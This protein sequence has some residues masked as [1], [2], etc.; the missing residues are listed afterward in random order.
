M[1]AFFKTDKFRQVL[2]DDEIDRVVLGEDCIEWL[3]VQLSNGKS[4]VAKRPIYEDWGWTMALTV[5]G[6]QL[7]LNVQDWSFEEGQTWHLWLE[8][9]GVLIRL[10]PGRYAAAS[11]LLRQLLDE[12]LSADSAIREVRW[13]E[14]IRT[15]S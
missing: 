5:D 11:K 7:W 9:R 14:A 6:A 13:S 4:V 15:T 2:D 10:N 8:P 3:R 1:H 12:V